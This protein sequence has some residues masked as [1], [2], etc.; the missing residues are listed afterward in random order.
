MDVTLPNGQVINGVPDGTTKA[1]LAQKL[2]ANGM[3]IPKEWLAPPVVTAPRTLADTL[4][5][6]GDAGKRYVSD[7]A[8]GIKGAG[9]NLVSTIMQYPFKSIASAPG[10][11]LEPVASA[12]GNTIADASALAH[13]AIDKIPGSSY[14]GDFD[15]KATFQQRKAEYEK[16][17]GKYTNPQTNLGKNLTDTLGATLKPVGDVMG[18]PGKAT[19]GIAKLGGASPETAQSVEQGTNAL[20]NVL[21]LGKSM[22]QTPEA[23]ER[24]AIPTKAELKQTSQIAYQRAKDAGATITGESFGKAVNDAKAALKEDGLNPKL[25]PATTAALEHISEHEGPITVSQLDTY[26]KV[27]QNAEKSAPIGSAD[28]RFAGKLVDSIDEY[29][30]NISPKDVIGG[31]TP[32]AISALKEAR[33]NWSRYRKTDTIDNLMDRVEL[34]ATQFSGSGAENAIRT[35]FRSLAMNKRRMSGFS[36][37]EQAAIKKVATGGPIDNALRY[38]GKL[39]PTGVVSAVAAESLGGP[40]AMVGGAISRKLARNSTEARAAQAQQIM[41][42]GPGYSPPPSAPLF[43]FNISPAVPAAGSLAEM[44]LTPEQRRQLMSAQLAQSLGAQ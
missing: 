31:D 18:L 42:A 27:A 5:D 30:D 3:D 33:S 25:N 38:F 10:A 44:A 20:T 41:R 13:S 37:A 43:P 14:I 12:V 11:I 8:S 29:M 9:K 15:P 2:Q 35:E 4:G 24:P 16:G 1:Q 34:R 28:A 40:A 39:A 19:S 36:A 32:A 6:I 21:A 26:R 7:Y 17:I 22:R 23:G